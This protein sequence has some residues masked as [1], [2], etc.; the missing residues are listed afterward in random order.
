[1]GGFDVAGW[2]LLFLFVSG[3]ITTLPPPSP[4]HPPEL[5]HKPHTYRGKHASWF[6]KQVEKVDVL[7]LCQFFSSIKIFSSSSLSSSSSLL[8]TARRSLIR[9]MD[10]AELWLQPSPAASWELRDTEGEVGTE[11]RCALGQGQEM[12]V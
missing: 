3:L 11:G 6:T 9:M 10:G 5:H 12:G 4:S 7:F 1:M 2:C 8:S